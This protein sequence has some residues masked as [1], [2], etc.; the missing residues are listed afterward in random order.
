M[1]KQTVFPGARGECFEE[2]L[3]GIS[4]H[5]GSGKKHWPGW[6]NL[7]A[8]RG[9]GHVDLTADVHALPLKT[10]SAVRAAAIHVVEHLWRWEVPEILREW[11]RILAP[12]GQLILELPC[13]DRVFHYIRTLEA[14]TPKVLLQM[15]AWAFWGD[16]KYRDPSMMHRWGYFRSELIQV[17]QQA[18]FE[19][20]QEAPTR[21]HR[22]DRD[23]RIV[24]WKPLSVKESAL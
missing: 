9:Q 11:R 3:E 20:V 17:M 19:R 7:D 24:G 1:T 23:M 6:V 18:G 22:K 5:L 21:Y 2:P 16:P 4:V 8:F 12:G 10:G 14:G 13:M 15:T